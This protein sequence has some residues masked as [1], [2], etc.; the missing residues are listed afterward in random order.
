MKRSRLLGNM[1]LFLK[2]TIY[3]C[4]ALCFPHFCQ[5]TYTE[6]EGFSNCSFQLQNKYLFHKI[7]PQCLGAASIFP[8]SAAPIFIGRENKKQS[9]FPIYHARI[10]VCLTSHNLVLPAAFFWSKTNSSC[11]SHCRN[12]WVQ[13]EDAALV[14]HSPGQGQGMKV[15]GVFTKACI[16]HGK[17]WEFP[18]CCKKST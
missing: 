7:V 14:E 13:C 8:S 15:S 4:S 11:P 3:N 2:V 17:G 12:S 9:H 6:R 1:S 10:Y 16:S 18:A 5:A